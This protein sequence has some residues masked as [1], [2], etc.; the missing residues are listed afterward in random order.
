MEHTPSELCFPQLLNTSCRKPTLPQSEV[1]FLHTLVSSIS[2]LTVALNLLVIISVSH[3]RQLHTPTNILLLSLAVS[4]FLVGLLL[5]PVEILRKTSCWFLGDLMCSLYICVSYSIPSASVGN[6]VLISL[7]RYVAICDPLHY[8]TR[9]TVR[10]VKLCV[11]LCWFCSV[12]Y[13]S[14]VLKDD[15][16]QPGRY[17]SCYG[18]CVVLFD[19]TADAIDLA[20]TFIVPV[21]VI[22]VL[23]MRVFVVAVSQARAMRSHITAVILQRSVTLTAKKSELKAART[24]GVLVVV[25]LI[26]LFPY[27]GMTLAGDSLLNTSSAFLGIYLFYFN[28][29]LNPVIYAMFYPWFRKSVKLIVTLQILQPGSCEANIL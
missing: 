27:Y 11:C 18:D 10:R 1:V 26:C 16:T 5:M 6:M 9:I 13:S 2:L 3:F 14:V 12:F 17:N 28:S 4:D 22:I 8:T 25:F 21:T 15:L 19:H 23:Y 24:L 29:C 20:L 7:D